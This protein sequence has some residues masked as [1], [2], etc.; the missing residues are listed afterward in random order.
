MFKRKFKINELAYSFL[1]YIVIALVVLAVIYFNLFVSPNNYADY[2][3]NIKDEANQI[4]NLGQT[5]FGQE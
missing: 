2:A 3:N 1:K 4:S 5:L